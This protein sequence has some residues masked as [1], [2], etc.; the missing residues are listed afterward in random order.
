[1]KLFL[2]LLLATVAIAERQFH[3]DQV[4]RTFPNESQLELFKKLEAKYEIEFW[5]DLGTKAPVDI[6]VRYIMLNLVKTALNEHGVQFEIFVEDVQ[7]S[8]EEQTD[9]SR[10]PQMSRATFD[11]N[12]YH[13]TEEINQ[14]ISDMAA[15]YADATEVTT[16][17]TYEGRTIRGLK[18][19]GGRNNPAFVITCGIH[20]REWVGPASC[21]YHIKYLLEGS[22]SD[23]YRSQVDYYIIPSANPD[24]YS[25]TWDGDRMWRKTRSK[26]N[27]FCDGVD[28][29]RNFDVNW[30]GAGASASSC[31]DAFYGPS[32]MSEAE[33][34]S[35][36]SFVASI[37]NVR[38][39]IDIHAYSQYW[40]FAYAYTYSTTPDHTFLTQVGDDSAAAIKATHGKTYAH[41]AISTV[42]YQASGST[43]DHMYINRG[44][45]CS[46]AAELRD[47]GRYG[48][49]L[50]ESQIQPTAEES[51]AGLMVIAGYIANG[52]C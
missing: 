9:R 18:I 48:F 19:S 35:L 25:Y 50:P 39:Y 20:A 52:Q 38:G 51:F 32:V 10:A 28:P 34:Q 40:M 29:N 43:T 22:S 3:G 47:T 30:S 45:K 26:N 8:V 15:A 49:L 27:L 17:K 41:G 36:D 42:I 13:T 11:Y 21:M 33:V 23:N 6:H 1:M 2:V 16:G 24:G 12:V 44:V 7:K 5:T 4:I 14:W 46:F 31:N 37:P